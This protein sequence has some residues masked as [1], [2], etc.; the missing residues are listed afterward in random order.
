MTE[1]QQSFGRYIKKC[2]NITTT[3]SRFQKMLH[4]SSQT[5]TSEP[6]EDFRMGMR[7]KGLVVQGMKTR[8]LRSAMKF[9]DSYTT[10]WNMLGAQ[11]A[12][13]G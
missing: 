4:F 3:A 7:P 11:E 5:I 6:S 9:I 1:S 10:I 12:T 8:L 2:S 13:S